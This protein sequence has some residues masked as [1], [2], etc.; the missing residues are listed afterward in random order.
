MQ[1]SPDPTMWEFE[2]MSEKCERS[3]RQ[4]SVT[5]FLLEHFMSALEMETKPDVHPKIFAYLKRV[6]IVYNKFA[7]D[8]LNIN[9]ATLS[10]SETNLKEN[11]ECVV[12]ELKYLVV[13]IKT[14]IN[15][16]PKLRTNPK[17]NDTV[18]KFAP[19]FNCHLQE[20]YVHLKY[21]VSK[22]SDEEKEMYN[23]SQS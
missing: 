1:D 8:Y 3:V 19:R 9:R 17:P 16:Y 13:N 2:R 4:M 12:D 23:L 22:M 6:H 15:L 11:I 5:I 18:H 20:W 21:W 10:F 7:T 14:G